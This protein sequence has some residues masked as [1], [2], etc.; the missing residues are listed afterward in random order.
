MQSGVV[1]R[2]EIA[3]HSESTIQKQ[4]TDRK[5]GRAQGPSFPSDPLPPARFSILR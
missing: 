2:S 4:I 1:A 3:G 5:Q